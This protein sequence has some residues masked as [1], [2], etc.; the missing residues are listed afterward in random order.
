[1]KKFLPQSL[2][3]LELLKTKKSTTLIFVIFIFLHLLLLNI[4]YAEWGDSYRILRGAEYLRNSSYP[5]DEK[6]PPLYSAIL[7]T[8]PSS[9]DPILWGRVVMFL[10]SI[11]TLLV[12]LK[13]SEEFLNHDRL[14]INIALL[15]LAFNPVFLYWSL[16]IYADV[17]FA[18]LVMITTLFYIKIFQKN[19]N[20]Y[21]L[22][23]LALITALSI[24]TRFE[25]YILFGAVGLGL[26]FPDGFKDY[27]KQLSLNLHRAISFGFVTLIVLIPYFIWRN[28]LDSSYLGEQTGREFGINQIL[29]FIASVLFSGGIL[30]YLYYFI[31]S[32]QD[33]VSSLRK[34]SLITS[35]TLVILLLTLLWPAAVPRT[36]TSA[37]PFM[38]LFFASLYTQKHQMT[39]KKFAIITS[40]L[41]GFYL[42][43]QYKYKLQFLVPNKNI[44]VLL[45]ILNVI[46]AVALYKKY[47]NALIV[48]LILSMMVWSLSVVNLHNDVFKVITE[49]ARF[50]GRGL[51]GVVAYNDLS[52]VSDWY[53]N[54]DPLRSNNVSGVFFPYYKKSDADLAKLQSVNASYLLITNEHNTQM[55]FDDTNKPYLKKVAEFKENI[56]GAEFFTKIYKVT[57]N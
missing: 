1:M 35:F 52:S 5:A 22:V 20:I 6:R 21:S 47:L 30:I 16:R 46:V 24:L 53:L 57:Y 10:V 12:F 45:I 9:V 3:I 40:A 8:R 38:C 49:G 19:R 56:N 44:L 11:S 31:N 7:A 29:I 23:G 55:T 39:L 4:N 25:G 2:N 48:M 37:I 18:L 26:L 27:K 32:A 54:N 34:N 17:F 51:T 43:V 50:S 42:L 41:F 33:F 28:P 15:S 13:V 14:K 36:L